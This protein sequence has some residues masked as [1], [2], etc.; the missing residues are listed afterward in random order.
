MSLPS[1]GSRYRLPGMPRVSA[2]RRCVLVLLPG[3]LLTACSEG[4]DGR[5]AVAAV[6]QQRPSPDQL[7][8]MQ[9]TEAPFRYPPALYAER[10]Q[11]DVLLRLYIDSAGAVHPESTMV[12]QSSGTSALDSAAVTGSRELRFA[13]ARR[14]GAPV[15]VTVHLPVQ[16]RHPGATPSAADSANARSDAPAARAP[17]G[18]P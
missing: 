18:T 9:N 13:P 15:G 7:P 5:D 17:G 6:T 4:S 16:F 2:A 12:V 14:D 1:F 11:A 8:V 3:V 10:V